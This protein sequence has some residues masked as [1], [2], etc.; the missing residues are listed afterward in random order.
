M[1][2]PSSAPASLPLAPSGPVPPAA[3]RRRPQPLGRVLGF[4][5]SKASDRDKR[6]IE[7]YAPCFRPQFNPRNRVSTVLGFCPRT[8]FQSWE[9]HTQVVKEQPFWDIIQERI[10]QERKEDSANSPAA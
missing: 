3:S 8:G 4:S 7:H 5:F 6:R 1:K 2:I 10:I 9:P